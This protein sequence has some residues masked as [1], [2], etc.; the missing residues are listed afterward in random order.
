[1]RT[2]AL[3]LI[4][5]LL[6]ILSSGQQLA[7]PEDQASIEGTVISAVSGEPVR[8]AQIRLTGIGE[9][10]ASL[11]ASSDAVGRF[12]LAALDAGQYRLSVSKNGFIRQ[13]Y[14]QRST[15]GPGALLSVTAG[16]NLRDVN[17][18][19]IPAGVVTGRVTDDDGEPLLGVRIQLVRFSYADGKRQ[20]LIV[21]GSITDD[22]GQYR[23]YGLPPGA[24]FIQAIYA[25]PRDAS[26]SAKRSIAQ[27]K[28]SYIPVFYP[29]VIDGD[30]AAPVLLREGEERRGIDF[31]I[32]R[33]RT[34]SVR[35]RVVN[36][37][38]L[39]RELVL[40]LMKPQGGMSSLQKSVAQVHEDGSFEFRG[41]APGSYLLKAVAGYEGSV[42]AAQQSLDV[43]ASDVEK[44]EIVLSA[45]AEV[46]GQ[47]QLQGEGKA[48]TW[49]QFTPYLIPLE[50]PLTI[51]D[52]GEVSSRN[53][54]SFRI[55]NLIPGE[56]RVS[57]HDLPD[58]FFVKSVREGTVDVLDKGLSLSG[59]SGKLDVVVSAD[60][61]RV[62][63]SILDEQKKGVSGATVVLVP[64]VKMR[65]RSDLFKTATTD[66]YGAFRLRGVTPGEYK[67]FAWDDVEPDSYLDPAFLAGFEA[68]GRA[69][70]V[71]EKDQ[72]TVEL[73]VIPTVH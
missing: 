14:G 49:E 25:D 3:A 64:D 62:E 22:L 63:G 12:K 29:G 54:G 16:Q 11:E 8:N 13:E 44:V 15:N 31:R 35:G 38:P 4:P 42:F 7:K 60:G 32:A 59:K 50:D 5:S 66:Q 46:I 70:S 18:R 27:Q 10:E 71:V 1:M 23:L 68:K 58:N 41:V 67:L 30:Q 45:A 28:S 56:Y 39:S 6:A 33:T 55:R 53:D 19:L 26:G 51:G 57:F 9:T 36:A 20:P 48:R 24:Y 73:A 72:A 37:G 2:V 21:G 52:S 17:L 61:A 69:I 65:G 47:I 43:G 34:V 40:G